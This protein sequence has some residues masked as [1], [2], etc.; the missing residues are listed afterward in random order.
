MFSLVILFC[1]VLSDNSDIP[2]TVDQL[3]KMV[4]EKGDDFEDKLCL[5]KN[6]VDSSLW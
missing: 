1:I 4:A 3:I 2:S 5:Q 6:D